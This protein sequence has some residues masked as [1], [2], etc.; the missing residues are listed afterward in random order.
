MPQRKW[1]IQLT[2]ATCTIIDKDEPHPQQK[3]LT[4]K[5]LLIVSVAPRL[6]QTTKNGLFNGAHKECCS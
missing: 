6:A 1:R 3:K 5:I 2:I 4:D